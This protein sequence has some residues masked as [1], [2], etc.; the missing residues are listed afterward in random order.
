[1]RCI[2]S[3]I[4]LICF[5]LMLNANVLSQTENKAEEV[6]QLMEKL[7]W[8]STTLNQN[9]LLSIS[10]KGEAANQLIKIGKP[11]TDALLTSLTNESKALAAHVILTI[12]WEPQNYYI[13]VSS[14]AV[15][16]KKLFGKKII[17]HT[18]DCN[19]FKWVSDKNGLHISNGDL[20]E[21]AFRWQKK[22]NEYR[23]RKSSLKAEPI[24]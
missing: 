16:K 14:N 10:P 23:L 1:M 15:Y 6:N 22:I 2:V 5:T 13:Y 24:Q 20:A 3:I 7:S 8:D 18:N 12:I 4:V 11:A 19:G 21:N 9:L 17:A